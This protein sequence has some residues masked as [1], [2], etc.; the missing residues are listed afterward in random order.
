MRVLYTGGAGLLGKYLTPLLRKQGVELDTPSHNDLDITQT[1]VPQNYDLI[2]HAAAYTDVLKA[3]TE[4]LKCYDVNI[5]G[6][7]HLAEAYATTPFV[8]ISSEYAHHPVNFYS[9]TKFVG[10]LVA[11]EIAEKCLVIRTLFKP[12][13]F[14]WDKAFTDQYTQ[15]DYIDVIAPLLI[16]Q[17]LNWYG[18]KSEMVYVGTGRKTIYDLAKRTRPDVR[19][20]SIDD[21]EGVK[22]PQDYE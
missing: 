11:N 18:K 12:T 4:R 6:T 2:I 14:P 17:I 15:G 1:I 10:E 9:T 16:E 19:E 21:I 20:G 8:Y 3:E 7:M 22:L 13:P 5:V